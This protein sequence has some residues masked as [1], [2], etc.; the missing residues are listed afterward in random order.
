MRGFEG[1]VIV[2]DVRNVKKGHGLNGPSNE[3]VDLAAAG[4]V[5]PV[6]V[7]RSALLRSRRTS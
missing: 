6:T 5:D 3:G 4:I 2:T 7:T 1:L